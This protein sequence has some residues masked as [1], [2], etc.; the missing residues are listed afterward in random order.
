MENHQAKLNISLSDRT[1][2]ILKQTK[3]GTN[4]SDSDVIELIITQYFR[5][6]PSSK[7]RKIA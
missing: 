4:L 1:H 5:M 3:K 7:K 6:I 2:E